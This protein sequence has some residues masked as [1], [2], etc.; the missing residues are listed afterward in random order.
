ML[1]D[2]LTHPERKYEVMIKLFLIAVE[3]GHA[4]ILS[5]LFDHANL[6]IGSLY[7]VTLIKSAAEKGHTQILAILLPKVTHERRVAREVIFMDSLIAPCRNGHV[8]VVKMLLNW[9]PEPKIINAIG[10]KDPV[11]P[12]ILHHACCGGSVEIVRLLKAAGAEHTTDGNDSIL[13]GKSD[14][15]L[16]IA[17]RHGHLGTLFLFSLLSLSLS[18]S[19]FP[20]LFLSL[21]SF[22]SFSLV[23]SHFSSLSLSHSAPHARSGE[24]VGGRVLI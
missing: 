24:S 18:L 3:A 13:P 20:S 11:M 17:V 16:V 15:P 6:Q 23:L 7:Y 4:H 19:I 8:E 5:I 2:L 14:P 10:R 21:S 12:T 22:L 1:L 9:H